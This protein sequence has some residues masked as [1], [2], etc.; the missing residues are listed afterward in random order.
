MTQKGKRT[1]QLPA[2]LES[3]DFSPV[4]Q[5]DLSTQQVHTILSACKQSTPD[6]LH[7]ILLE[8]RRHAPSGLFDVFVWDVF[9][10]WQS[11]GAPQKER[12]C[13][14]S[15][16]MLGSQEVVFQ[17]LPWMYR[18]RESGNHHQAF[19][20]L[21]CFLAL[22]S[23]V[24]LMKVHEISQNQKLKSLRAKALELIVKIAQSRGLSKEQLEDRI[25][26]SCGLDE[27]GA[28]VFD[29]GSRKFFFVMGAGLKPS[30]RD[31]DNKVKPDLPEP[32]QRDNL[33][34][35]KQEIAQWKELKKNIKTVAKVQAT[36]LE[37]ALVTGRRWTFSEFEM[38]LLKHPLMCHLVRP[39]VWAGYDS[40]GKMVKTFRV[41]EDNQCSD[42]YDK[43]TEI[44]GLHEI[45]LVHPLNCP[46]DLL[47]RWGELLT[48]YEI[49][50]PFPQLGRATFAL[51]SEEKDKSSIDRFNEF[52]IPAIAVPSTLER[53]GWS[54]GLPISHGYYH[55]HSKQFYG[56][57]LTVAVE[58]DDG[59]QMQMALESEPQHLSGC[60]F[61]SGI[62]KPA[63]S[64]DLRAAIPL[65]DVDPVVL[66]EVL[67]D[68]SLLTSKAKTD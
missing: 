36:K 1:A 22:G 12:W 57:N 47:G 21:D 24:A 61:L 43:N 39:L 20:G 2:F 50:P 46:L 5:W 29:F 17:L 66:S 55:C 26:P 51:T 65:K 27:N 28:R 13:I 30:V 16:G 41:A 34:L 63:E 32:T 67:S 11:A 4:L 9:T 68:L 58:Y 56:A 64:F 59:I 19:W 62:H 25:V 54:R 45:G 49:V 3:A 8:I 10:R 60:F 18:W 14:W 38:Y 7:P 53:L 37:Q 40:E 23:D 44:A 52:S 35:A 6:N 42:E 31:E 33:E 15:V 48:D